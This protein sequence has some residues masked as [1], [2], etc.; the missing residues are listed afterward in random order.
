MNGFPLGEVSARVADGLVDASRHLEPALIKR[1]H[2]MRDETRE[3]LASLDAH[4]P[5]LPRYEAS[6]EVLLM[7]LENLRIADEQGI[8]MC[9][10]TGMVLVFIE[11]GPGETVD[12]ASIE[13]AIGS[14][15][16]QA[17]SQGHFRNSVVADPV[18]AR[19]NTAT[20]LP[21]VIH[22]SSSPVPGLH[23]RMMLKGFG[24]ENCTSLAML[25]P[26]AGADGVVAAVREM[27]RKAGGKP[28][29]PIVVGVGIGGSAE[30]ALLL[31]KK[32]LLRPTGEAHPEASYANLERRIE[33]EVQGL[34]IGPGG[35]GGPLT[36]LAVA[37][38]HEPTHIAGL[39]VAVS[40][41][42]WA[43]RKAHF[44]I[45]GRDDT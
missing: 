7:I 42:C 4:D 26:T 41:S 31:S 24:S 32:A 16:T 3:A 22:W 29:P 20:N 34:D 21:A 33:Q 39:P 1:L 6:L 5:R 23:V 15:I 38:E 44:S 37:V 8:P 11:V 17:V 30:R 14:G 10:D 27:V 9:Q 43:D 36:A 40:I 12:L 28:C 18:Y 25:N 35:F 13:A 2:H 45:G 19:T